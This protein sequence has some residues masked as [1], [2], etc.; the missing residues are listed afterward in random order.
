MIAAL[1]AISCY[2]QAA[3]VWKMNGARSRFSGVSH[4]K[5]FV[6]RIEPHPK[7]EIFTVDTTEPDGRTTSSS[8]I[9]YFDGDPRPVD[10]FLCSGIQTSRR[11][12]SGTVEILRMCADGGWKRL[13]RRNSDKPNEMV[14]EIIE[15]PGG[16]GR[17]SEGRL[18]LEKQ[19]N[20]EEAKK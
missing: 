5:R 13:V 10:D 9:L 6:V 15:Q 11:N 14:L 2:G 18:V 8:T 17:R 20:N 19:T 16:N 12:E 4:P 3:G 1:L 7:G